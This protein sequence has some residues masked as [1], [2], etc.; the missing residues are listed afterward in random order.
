MNVEYYR[1][2]IKQATDALNQ[3]PDIDRLYV[4]SEQR[5]VENERRALLRDIRHYERL[6]ELAEKV[7]GENV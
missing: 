3:L 1:D 4:W 5:Q 6:I 2:Q 7:R